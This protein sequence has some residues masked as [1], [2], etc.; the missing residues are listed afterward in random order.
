MQGYITTP[1][2]AAAINAAVSAAQ[3]QRGLP[4]YWLPGSYPIHQ[5]TYAGKAFIPLTDTMLATN[6]RGDMIPQDFPEFAQLTAMLGG[7]D[8]RVD[9]DPQALI[10][11]NAPALDE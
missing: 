5:G 11:P 9:L 4:V 6:L 2:T 3:T 7:L 10:D 8:A 1:D